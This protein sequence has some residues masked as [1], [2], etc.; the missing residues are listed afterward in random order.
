MRR[1]ATN[2]LL[3]FLAA[4][5]FCAPAQAQKTYTQAELDALLAPIALQPDGVVSQVLMAATYPEDVAAAIS[6]CDTTPSGCRAIG[7]SSESSSG[8]E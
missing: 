8:C 4:L 7:A 3:A 2:L 5:A 1:L 6:T